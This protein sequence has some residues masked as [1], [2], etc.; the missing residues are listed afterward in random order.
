MI[1]VIHRALNILE[2]VARDRDKE[3]TLSEI[4]DSL[5]LNHGTC[6]NIIKTLLVRKYLEQTGKRQG[7]KLGQQ[8]YYLT[9]NYSN[10]RELL[11]VSVEPI[12]AL[13]IKL[14]ESCILAIVKE[15]MRVILHKELGNHELQVVSSNKEK[16][17]YLKATGRMIL[18]CMTQD[19]Q[20]EF[21]RKF[22][23]PNEMWPEVKNEE[24]LFTE[25]NKIKEK[26]CSVHYA[27]SHIVEIGVPIY[28]K[29]KIVASL[30]VY[31]PEARFTY[32]AQE[33]IFSEINKTAHH[34]TLEMG[35]LYPEE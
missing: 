11:N 32:K 30:G 12:K 10:K 27:E 22:G 23:L 3:H 1:Q 28:K 33:Q 14:N 34:I 21:V 19:E 13:C 29:G 26:Q 5:G 2:L 9:A 15:N 4:S 18:A 24:E 25:L 20:S 8:A 35:K 6:A 16:N 17:V 31:L 7:Y